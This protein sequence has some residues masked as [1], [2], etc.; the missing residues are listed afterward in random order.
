MKSI[1]KNGLLAL[2]FLSHFI[3]ASSQCPFPLVKIGVV[4][5]GFGYQGKG[6]GT[7][8][9]Q[10]GHKD[11]TND[12]E[13]TQVVKTKDP[14]PLDFNS[15]GTNIAGIITRFAGKKHRNFCLVIIKYYDKHSM[16]GVLLTTK[17]FEYAADLKLDYVN[18]S[19]GGADPSTAEFNAVKRYLDGGGKFITAAG[20]NAQNLDLPGA[21]Y[22]PATYG[23]N[24][25]ISVGSTDKKGNVLSSSN[26]GSKVTR[27]EV[28]L[29][30]EAFGIILTGTSQAVATATGK[31]VFEQLNTKANSC[32]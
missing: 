4:D 30:V 2:L 19:G 15:H 26:Y 12:Q 31:L 1:L 6:G 28:G 21:G 23:D 32:R 9:C 20:N 14:V 16:G 25:I 13:F 10:E 29:N 18:Y 5:T 3:I 7:P 24:R 22:F 8:L 27:W 11:F 17:S